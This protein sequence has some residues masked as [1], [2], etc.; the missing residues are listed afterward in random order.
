[1]RKLFILSAL[2]AC[3]SANAVVVQVGTRAA[4]GST[5]SIDW[6]QFGPQYT[7]VPS[8]SLGSTAN[9]T[10]FL[11]SGNGLTLYDQ[12]SG[13][14]GNFNN[15]EHVLYTDRDLTIQFAATQGAIGFEMQANYFGAFVGTM[16]AYDGLGSLLG[17]FNVNGNS[18]T[19]DGTAVFLGI[20]STQMDI[21]KVVISNA[22]YLNT[23]GFGINQVS[24]DTCKAVPEPASMAALG[25][26]V[27]GILK[28]RKKA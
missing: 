20:R 19:N 27:V 11:V 26:G 21:A 18:D 5:D 17:T 3:V 6:S 28:R 16:K 2:A 1:M 14:N 7:S 12:G 13:W 15:G 23:T 9:S 10:A 4:L 25:L 8:P 24:L 22:G